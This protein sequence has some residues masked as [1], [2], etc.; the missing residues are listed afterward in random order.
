VRRTLV[1]FD[2]ATYQKL[3][4]QAFRQARSLASVVRELVARGLDGG[5]AGKQARAGRF[6][7]VASGRSRQGRRS[8]VSEAHDQALAEAFEK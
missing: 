8:A 3:R 2:E 1:Q 4:Q 5:A 7:S 6:R